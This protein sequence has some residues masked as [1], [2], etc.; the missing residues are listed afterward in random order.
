MKKWI[1]SFVLCGNGLLILLGFIFDIWEPVAF[2]AANILIFF[3][4]PH[5]LDKVRNARK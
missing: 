1:E 3:G 5:L 2:G 4:I